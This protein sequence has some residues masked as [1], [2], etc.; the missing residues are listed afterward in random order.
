[1]RKLKWDY[2]AWEDYLY[3]QKHDKNV[4]KKINSIIRDIQRTP[5]NGIGN[6]E[7][8]PPTKRSDTPRFFFRI[9]KG[10]C[11]TVG[12][13]D[14]STVRQPPSFLFPTTGIFG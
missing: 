9:K 14:R 2:D 12:R 3:W 6:P 7:S 1:M 4:L 13:P 10:G 5:F 8:K 11:C